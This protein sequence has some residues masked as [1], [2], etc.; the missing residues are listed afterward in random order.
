LRP[1][2]ERDAPID[3]EAAL[4]D[5]LGRLREIETADDIPQSENPDLEHDRQSRR[6]PGTIDRRIDAIQDAFDELDDYWGD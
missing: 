4:R 2:G 5:E 3:L 6:E 1:S